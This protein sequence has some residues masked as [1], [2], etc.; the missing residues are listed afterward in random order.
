M[1]VIIYK[2][3]GE[4]VSAEE[5]KAAWETNTHGAGLMWREEGEVSIRKGFMT[6]DS[7]VTFLKD[8]G[9]LVDGVVPK[10]PDIAFHFRIAT[11]GG[12]HPGRTHPFPI[13]RSYKLQERLSSTAKVAVMHNGVIGTMGGIDW[14]DTQEIVS[15]VFH[16]VYEDGITAVDL[17]QR[18]EAA[19]P[20]ISF[21]TSKF[22]IMT[23][24]LIYW[25]GDFKEEDGLAFS[26]LNHRT[27]CRVT[28]SVPARTY[29]RALPPATVPIHLHLPTNA[30]VDAIKKYGVDVVV[31]KI[32][33]LPSCHESENCVLCD[34]FRYRKGRA[35]CKVW[36]SYKYDAA[37]YI[38]ALQTFIE[39]LEEQW[40][41]RR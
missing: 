28:R 11:S 22:L 37:Q 14:S 10:E 1:C 27:Q 13:T 15:T 4:I 30:I 41:R 25:L 26:N 8:Q 34:H 16:H 31:P 18:V 39:N 3:V 19:L 38:P 32:R 2:P 5:L 21:Y 29:Q 33:L 9:F 23:G 12:I 36:R 20:N 6:F 24:E 40:H 7:L 35:I 17:K